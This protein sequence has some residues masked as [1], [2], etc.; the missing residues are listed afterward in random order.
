MAEERLVASTRE[1]I[2]NLFRE[3]ELY[4]DPEV[5]SHQYY[6]SEAFAESILLDD[7][8]YLPPPDSPDFEPENS[9]PFEDDPSNHPDLYDASFTCPEQLSPL[10]SG[11]RFGPLLA[12]MLGASPSKRRKTKGAPM[13]C[14]GKQIAPH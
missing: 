14:F 3:N 1:R 4:F 8:D 5:D 11:L 9:W 12:N 13:K 2:I 10:L 7:P 6:P